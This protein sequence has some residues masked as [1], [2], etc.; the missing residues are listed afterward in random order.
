MQSCSKPLYYI[1]AIQSDVCSKKS[2]IVKNRWQPRPRAHGSTERRS[3]H[4][5]QKY[6]F[7]ELNAGS[8]VHA[9]IDESPFNSFPGVFLL[10][11]HKHVVVEKLLQ[12]LVGKV[13]AKLLETVEL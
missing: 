13:D 1:G 8:Q 3:P 11:Q 7:N 6:L 4:S 5:G 2:K 12:F 10:F 9:E